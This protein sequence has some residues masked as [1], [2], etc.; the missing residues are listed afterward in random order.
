MLYECEMNQQMLVEL[1]NQFSFL[2]NLF[3]SPKSSESDWS[4]ISQL[5][6]NH[7]LNGLYI[8]DLQGYLPV[9]PDL[10]SLSSL[11]ELDWV[12]EGDS[13][14]LMPSL[15]GINSLTQLNLFSRTRP[16][17]NESL[18][19]SLTELINSNS[20]SLRHIY[21]PFLHEVEFHSLNSFFNVITSCSNLMRL[22]LSRT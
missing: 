19:H 9:T 6:A 11:I 1:A 4:I 8:R 3:Y 21:L 22:E 15:Q 10:S 18:L 7:Q 2:Q 17:P 13:Y 20:K 14:S 5:I 12:T 16:S